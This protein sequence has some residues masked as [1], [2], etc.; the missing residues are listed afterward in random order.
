MFKTKNII[1]FFSS[2]AILLLVFLYIFANDH[3]IFGNRVEKIGI[4]GHIFKVEIVSEKE[5]MQKGLGGRK[6]LCRECGMLFQFNETGRYGFSMKNM[7]FPLDFLWVLDGK[8]VHIEKNIP[9]DF[10]GLLVPKLQADQ[11]LEINAG[12]VDKMNIQTGNELRFL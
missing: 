8:I 12:L 1:I 3:F 6:D 4:N 10:R 9:A 7:S 11:V 5:K 2:L